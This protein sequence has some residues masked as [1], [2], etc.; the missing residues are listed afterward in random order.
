MELKNKYNVAIQNRYN[1]M[2]IITKIDDQWGHAKRISS[3]GI[4]GIYIKHGEN[5]T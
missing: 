3:T 2:E 1:A 4:P 5:K